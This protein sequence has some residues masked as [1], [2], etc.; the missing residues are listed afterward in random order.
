M[1]YIANCTAYSPLQLCSCITDV[2]APEECKGDGP[3]SHQSS[4]QQSEAEQ[5]PQPVTQTLSMAT[6][7]TVTMV[8]LHNLVSFCSDVS[9]LLFLHI[10]S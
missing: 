8:K 3:A 2:N 7:R 5:Q 9:V 1:V 4:S 6:D 10:Q